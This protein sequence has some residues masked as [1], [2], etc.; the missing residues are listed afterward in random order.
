MNQIYSEHVVFY[1][2]FVIRPFFGIVSF[3]VFKSSIATYC[4]LTDD[5]LCSFSRVHELGPWL[6]ADHRLGAAGLRE[7]PKL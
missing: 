5:E 7:F 3:V 1:D 6:V 2:K 4:P